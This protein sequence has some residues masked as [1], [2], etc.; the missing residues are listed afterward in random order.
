VASRYGWHAGFGLAGIGMIFGLSLFFKYQHILG[1]I[2][3]SSRPDLISKTYAGMTPF[4]IIL[5]SAIGLSLIFSQTFLHPNFFISV[6]K[7]FAV[8]VLFIY[9][10]IIVQSDSQ[11]RRQLIA[12]S[13]MMLM[14][15][16]FFA[17]EMQ[18][19]SLIN[20]FTERNVA[21]AFLGLSIPPGAS[22]AL[23]PIC[24][25]VIGLLLSLSLASNRVIDTLRILFSM[26]AMAACF[27]VLYLG[28]AQAGID[29]QVDYFYL[30]TG[31]ALMSLGEVLI[32]PV[33]QSYVSLLA[34]PS[35]K[36]LIM[37]IMML[38]LAFSNLAG[39]VIAEFMSVPTTQGQ[40]DL[41]VSLA[42]YQQGFWSIALFN[43]YVAAAFIPF[44]LYLYAVLKRTTPQQKGL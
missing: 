33:V 34:P 30:M 42:V 13:I 40:V 2:G 19:G 14:L 3:L 16:I 31:I 7:Y 37:G 28:C 6:L 27:F 9:G 44:A 17:L 41:S 22:Q 4:W 29:Y 5:M 43:L 39:I 15:M 25:I 8:A 10:S 20:L 24:I 26:I 36:G 12:I 1:D 35:H 38:A 18:L 21:K 23:N 32:T 11:N